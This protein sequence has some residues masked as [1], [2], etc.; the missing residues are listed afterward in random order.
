MFN[1]SFV[2][3]EVEMSSG[4]GLVRDVLDTRID[5]G[6]YVVKLPWNFLWRAIYWDMPAVFRMLRLGARTSYSDHIVP[7]PSLSMLRSWER[8]LGRAEGGPQLKRSIQALAA[9]CDDIVLSLP[10]GFGHGCDSPAGQPVRDYQ[11]RPEVDPLN[12][13][14]ALFFA[15]HLN[16]VRN[17]TPA[18]DDA[19]VYNAGDDAKHAGG[20]R[21]I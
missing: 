2:F 9:T 20:R 8:Q 3:S 16:D 15:R 10:A 4:R 5:I 6:Q 17:F 11:G 7:F 21:R 14:R 12:L 19:H 13:L 1:V 18:L